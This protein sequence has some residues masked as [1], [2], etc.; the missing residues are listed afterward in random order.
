[1]KRIGKFYIDMVLIEK[2]LDII[3]QAFSFLGIV[4]TRAEML[5]HKIAIEYYALSSFFDEVP[6]CEI[7][8]EYKLIFHETNGEFKKA[9]V[10]KI[11][12]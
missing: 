11:E 6:D 2:E 12:Q 9:E 7:I 3:R 1:M 8:P 10:I 5:Y 4:P